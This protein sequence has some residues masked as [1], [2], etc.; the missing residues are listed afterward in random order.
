MNGERGCQ[1]RTSAG[2]YL[3]R[4]SKNQRD[5]ADAK[6]TLYARAAL[7][8]II[9]GCS[10]DRCDLF[11]DALHRLVDFRAAPTFLGVDPVSPDRGEAQPR[12]RL[13]SYVQ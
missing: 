11:L 10:V 3:L 1:R 13:F 7:H 2:G 5:N 6:Q 4:L 12:Y 9:H 8:E